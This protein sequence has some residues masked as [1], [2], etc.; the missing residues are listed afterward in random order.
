VAGC[1]RYRRTG[2]FAGMTLS[3]EAPLDD[4]PDDLRSLL[5]ATDL[6]A[7]AA[8]S[9]APGADRFQHELVVEQAGGEQ[10]AVLGE[11]ELPDDL[12][13]LVDWLAAKARGG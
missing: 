13:P 4:L 1:V 11:H 5:H 6:N 7:V 9:P 8:G 3:A 2:G 12:K 10:R